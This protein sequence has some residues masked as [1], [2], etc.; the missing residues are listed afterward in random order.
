MIY[1][2]DV[3]I[4]EELKNCEGRVKTTRADIK[5]IPSYIEANN[6]EMCKYIC[7]NKFTVFPYT[8]Y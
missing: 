5:K 1:V 4:L 3:S 7:L 2:R 8:L 6:S